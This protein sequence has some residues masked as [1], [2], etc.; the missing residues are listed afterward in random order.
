MA[1]LLWLFHK[2]ADS[3]SENQFIWRKFRDERTCS[4][5]DRV[6][7]SSP[8]DCRVF[9]GLKQPRGGR[10]FQVDREVETFVT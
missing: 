1:H 4:N 3:W 7:N 8:K 9:S 10:R 5:Y 2:Y 6:S